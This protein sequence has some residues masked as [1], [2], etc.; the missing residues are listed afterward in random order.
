MSITNVLQWAYAHMEYPLAILLIVPLV[1][2][3]MWIIKRQFV[4]T[5]DDLD[6]RRQKRKVRKNNGSKKTTSYSKNCG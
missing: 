3:V 6:A 4:I 5:K 2:L 1:L